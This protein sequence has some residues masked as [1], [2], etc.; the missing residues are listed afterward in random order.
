MR[1]SLLLS[2]AILAVAAPALASSPDVSVRIGGDLVEEADKLGQREVQEQVDRLAETVT[3]TLDRRG[4]LDGARI[5]LVVVDL[6]PNRPTF[7]QLADQPGLDG[8]RSRSIGGAAIEGE[9]VTTSGQRIPVRYDWY[10]HSLNDVRGFA[11]WQD[12]DR[13]FD[14]F[15]V[16]LAEGRYTR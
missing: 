14:R 8:L 5:D 11:V 10:S 2:A 9:I 1:K 7:Q 13:A 6:K 15:A 3:R 4:A 16:N 12:A